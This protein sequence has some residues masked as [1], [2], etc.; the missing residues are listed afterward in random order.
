MLILYCAEQGANIAGPRRE[1]ENEG[2]TSGV[3]TI[4]STKREAERVRYEHDDL[5][6]VYSQLQRLED[7]NM[8]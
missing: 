1:N 8:M 4:E 3:S 6:S 5:P 2:S 7:E